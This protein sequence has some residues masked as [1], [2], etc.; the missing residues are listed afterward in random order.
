LM[1][2]LSINFFPVSSSICT[3][4]PSGTALCCT[5]KGYRKFSPWPGELAIPVF[6]MPYHFGLP[7]LYGLF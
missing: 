2:S 5:V 4:T 7:E 6:R 1:K 3:F